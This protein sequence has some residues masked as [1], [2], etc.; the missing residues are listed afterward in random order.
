MKKT[1]HPDDE[2]AAEDHS[3]YFDGVYETV[4]EEAKKHYLACAARLRP[5][6]ERERELNRKLAN[7]NH[8]KTMENTELQRKLKLIAEARDSEIEHIVYL[9]Q[10]IENQKLKIAELEQ[11]ANR[12]STELN[13][14]HYDEDDLQNSID[15]A[16]KTERE[17]AAKCVA[18]SSSKECCHETAEHSIEA[19]LRCND[20][21]TSTTAEGETNKPSP[22]TLS[23]LSKEEREELE[24][25]KSEEYR[26]YPHDPTRLVTFKPNDEEEAA[27]IRG[28]EALA[29]IRDKAQ[30]YNKNK[31]VKK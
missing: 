25:M 5:E 16:V 1:Y 12:M 19:I 4:D 26:A 17:R 21:S 24:K 7:H 22:E 31:E 18:T 30:Q 28:A 29:H 13:K 20:V 11:E 8:D 9:N 23:K 10:E 2:K 15:A 6:I 3:K 27:F 14:H